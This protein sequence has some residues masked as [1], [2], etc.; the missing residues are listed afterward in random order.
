[1]WLAACAAGQSET[2]VG[3][4]S[5]RQYG[6]WESA[7][8][9]GGGYIQNVVVCPSVPGRLYAYVDVGGAYR[10]DD[11]GKTWRMLHGGMPAGDGFYGVRGLWV[12]PED[13]NRLVIAVGNQW[14]S[15]RGLF[16]SLDGGATWEKKADAPFLGNEQHRS[17]GTVL[18]Q[19]PDGSLLAGSAGGGLLTSL[20]RGETWTTGDLAGVNFTDLKVA[21]DGTLYACA[22]PH[23]MPDRREIG[24]GF[25]R[26]APGAEWE[27]LP[28]GPEEIVFA[29]DGAL[30]GIFESAKVRRST[31]KGTTWSDFSEGLPA[32]PEDR[33]YTSESRFRAL[34]AGPDFLLIGSSRGTVYRRDADAEAWQPVV[35]KGVTEE[36]EGQPW[37]GRMREGAWQHYGAA[38]GSLVIDPAD[39][40]R[41]WFTDWYGIYETR[42]AGAHWTLRI[43]G[44]EVTVIHA[45]AQDPADPGRV[46]AGMAD[47]GYVGSADGGR[48]YGGEKF[49][50]N[51]K[52]LALDNSLPGR[53]YGTGSRGGEWK[54][55]HLWVSA[56]GGADWIVAPM[57][58]LPPPAERWMNSVAVRPGHPYE[59][60]VALAGPVGQGGGVWVSSDGGRTFTPQTEGME[61]AG[62]FFHREIWGRV[63]ELAWGA[64]GTM[65][66]ASHGT[67]RL[68]VK[69]GDAPW[70][71][72]A[73][74]LP[75]RP[76]QVRV[77]DGKFYMTRGPGGLWRSS[78]GS[79]WERV[80][81]EPAE[82]LAVDAA[83]PGRLAVAVDGK[84]SMSEDGGAN[85]RSLGRPPMGQISAL[86]FAGQRLMA[87]TK[88]GGFFL[89]RLGEAGRQ[90]LAGPPSPGLLPVA[91]ETE[92]STPVPS[93][94]WSKPWTKS[95]SLATERADGIKGV[96]LR[97][98]GGVAAGST[99]LIFPATGSAFRMSGRWSV[100][101]D[102]AA[103]KLAARA[104]DA[105]GTQIGWF[106]LAETTDSSNTT[107]ERQI[108]LPSEAQRGEIVLLFEGDGSVELTDLDFSR[109]DPLFGHPAVSKTQLQT[110]ETP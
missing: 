42:D 84:I 86:A 70:R 79:T 105:G 9:G 110:P 6:E 43:D 2:T 64:D 59:V 30:I 71:E 8:F 32:D 85:W 41:W 31:D 44:I 60:A 99:G 26:K 95:G 53:I 24:G 34:A 33:G 97:S 102:G 101:G 75:G 104:L 47:N 20:D 94:N 36:M 37:W 13:P 80:F 100:S 106:P 40:D 16:L 45:I 48:T 69:T 29:P 46:H 11:G 108:E 23:T 72:V 56:D 3:A 90:V 82:I 27:S 55:D 74:D 109:A 22:L 98:E 15:N 49:T 78:D 38:M 10:S 1:M 35:R 4:E 92:F 51:M 103:A 7:S 91:E 107:F 57:R 76:F 12:C 73:G 17:C 87:G 66:A 61:K 28:V 96:V 50:S 88:G 25:F 93:F 5:P 39:P 77:Q 67:G 14:T 58:G 62:D 68:F 54:A 21:A 18:V 19:L 65:V 81:S 89:T 63:A 83:V 52:A